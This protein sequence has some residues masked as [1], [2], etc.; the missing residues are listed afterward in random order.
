V[1]EL[2]SGIVG[3]LVVDRMAVGMA[4]DMQHAAFF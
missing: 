4:V 1:A 3:M 2:R